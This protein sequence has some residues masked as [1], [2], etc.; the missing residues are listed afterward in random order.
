MDRRSFLKSTSIAAGAAGIV[1]APG[2]DAALA[3]PGDSIFFDAGTGGQVQ[4]T[5]GKLIDNMKALS[6]KPAT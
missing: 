4:P 2:V 3:N 5:A 1:A 6:D